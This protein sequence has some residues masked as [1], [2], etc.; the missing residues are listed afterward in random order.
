MKLRFLL[1]WLGF[2]VACVAAILLLDRPA[3]PEKPDISGETATLRESEMAEQPQPEPVTKETTVTMGAVGDLLLHDDVIRGGQTAD[4]YDFSNI[5]TWF[6]PYIS[7]LD[8]A[9]ADMEGTLCSDEYGY[10]YAGY[11]CFN[12]PDAIVDAALQDPCMASNPVRCEAFR[13]RRILEAVSG[14]G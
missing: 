7:A 5:F 6:A 10:P 2:F 12:S 14:R 9:A 4:G 13:L 11:P 3:E 1:P 8:Y